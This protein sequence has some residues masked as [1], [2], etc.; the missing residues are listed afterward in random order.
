MFAELPGSAHKQ[1]WWAL[2]T[3]EMALRLDRRNRSVSIVDWS[4]LRCSGQSGWWP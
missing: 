4:P 3:L 1:S 2:P